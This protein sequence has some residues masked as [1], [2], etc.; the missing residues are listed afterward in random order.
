MKSFDPMQAMNAFAVGSQI[1]TNIRDKQTDNG[2]APMVAKGDFQGAAEYAGQRGDVGS[3]AHFGAQYQDQIA[4]MSEAQRAE[5]LQRQETLARTAAGLQGIPYEQRRAALQQSMP[6]LQQMGLDPMQIQQFDPTDD[7]IG[8]VLA[9]VTPMAE[10]LKGADSYTLSP[11]QVRMRGDQEVARGPEKPANLPSGMVLNPETGQAEYIPGYIDG[12]REIAEARGSNANNVQSTFTGED[13]TQYIVRRDGSL[14]PLGVKARNPF[15]I[16][17]VGGVPTAVDRLTGQ[18]QEVASAQQVGSNKAEIETITAN[19]TFRREQEQSLPKEIAQIDRGIA[20]LETL[21]DSPGFNSRYG[22]ASVIPAIPGTQM[23]DTQA[24]IDQLGGQAFLTAFES[25]KGGGQ[26]TEIEGQKAT[27]AMTILTSQ[28]IRPETAAQAIEDLIEVR[29]SAKKRMT[30][31]AQSS[32][33]PQGADAP[34]L[35][36]NPAT[37]EFE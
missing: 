8:Q 33:A 36:Y 29:D 25:L 2:L 17:D 23:A 14:E 31:Q 34:A 4:Q 21:K 16:T 30:A 15:Q 28:G 11:G 9:Q 24:I 19:E 27:Q 26:I 7:A 3:A 10:L 20:T 37:G 12:Q 18:G 5:A 32:Y 1:G 35:K 22:F 6:A 13:G